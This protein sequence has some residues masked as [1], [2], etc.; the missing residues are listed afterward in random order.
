[1]APV[2]RPQ[3]EPAAGIHHF[4]HHHP[5][6]LSHHH[7]QQTPCSACAHPTSVPAYGC[8]LCN[9]YLHVSCAKMPQQLQHP[10]DSNRTHALTLLPKPVYPEGLFSCDA[11]G[12][13]GNGFS[14]HC[15]DCK[16]DLHILCAALPSAAFVPS[17]Q[18]QLTILFAPPYP[19]NKFV[20]DVCRKP[21]SKTW[22]YSCRNCQFDVHLGCSRGPQQPHRTM[23]APPHPH[24]PYAPAAARPGSLPSRFTN[25]AIEC[26]V[27]GIFQAVAQNVVNA[28]MDGNVS[29]LDYAGIVGD[30]SGAGEFDAS[31]VEG[32]M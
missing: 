32:S 18:H 9:Y 7:H 14:Y 19:D 31:G 3:S 1:M 15:P 22:L 25:A 30:G 13:H 5:L 2:T 11:C 29:G 10:F 8:Q 23:S 27:D 6:Q 16:I 28:V 20:C 12:H 26:A 21:G 24:N 4:A 17:H